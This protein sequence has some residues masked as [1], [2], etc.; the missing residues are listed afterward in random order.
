MTIFK[1]A[2][3]PEG[4]STIRRMVPRQKTYET[5]TMEPKPGLATPDG[6]GHTAAAPLAIP[7]PFCLTSHAHLGGV[8]DHGGGPWHLRGQIFFIIVL[9][10][11]ASRTP[12]G[13]TERCQTQG[14]GL[15]LEEHGRGRLPGCKGHDPAWA[16]HR[17]KQPS[18][19]ELQRGYRD[20]EGTRW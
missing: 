15:A 9:V 18:P 2:G 17:L 20:L 7:V 10:V 11:I 14:V 19:Q 3:A 5:S 4:V 1:A 13:Q 12:C 8:D 16:R 6:L